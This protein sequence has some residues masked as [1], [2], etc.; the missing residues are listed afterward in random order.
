M[1]VSEETMAILHLLPNEQVEEPASQEQ[2]RYF[3]VLVRQMCKQDEYPLSVRN[4][5]YASKSKMT[6]ALSELKSSMAGTR[7]GIVRQMCKQDEYPL[8]VRNE[9][10]ASKSKMTEALSELKSSMAGTRY[11]IDV[12]ETKDVTFSTK[13]RGVIQF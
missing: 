4:E 1:G 9:L 8:S 7:Y 2:K 13:T 10:Y 6:E 11:G 5:L 3:A 12:A